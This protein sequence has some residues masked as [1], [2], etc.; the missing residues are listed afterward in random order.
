MFPSIFSDELG[1][2]I[3]KGLPII[4]SWGLEYVDL[5]GRVF[6][7]SAE[8][9]PADKLADLKKLFD[10]HGM[11]LGCIQSSLAKVH[12]PGA[13]RQKAEAEKLEG[14]IR[15]ADAL[16]CRLVRSFHYWQ[17]PKED[18]GQLA[19]RPD[20]LQKVLDMFAPLAE[21]AQKAGL[22]LAFE[23]CDVTPDEIFTVLDA[24]DVPQWGMAWDVANTWG[25]EEC[26]EDED[27]YILRMAKRARLLHV[28]ANGS[29]IPRD[30]RYIPYDK[31]LEVCHN[32]GMPGP[33]SVETHNPDRSV[34]NEEMSRRVVQVV[35]KAW[36][37]AAPGALGKPRIVRT[38]SRPWDNEPVGFVVVGLGM[39]QVRSKD[40]TRTSGT[41]LVGV[42]DLIEDRAKRVGEEFDVPWST[43]LAAWL[44]NDEVE[45]V[46]VITETG[47]HAK[48][49]CQALEAGKHVITTKPMEANVANCDKMIS[50][51]EEKGLL[52]GVDLG[53]RYRPETQ[54]LRAAVAAGK[55]G[56]LL[57]GN[58][59]LKILRDKKYFDHNG[60]W[61]GT[62]ALDG[63]G[64]MSNQAIHHID[65]VVY[66]VGMPE[67]VRC[68][69]WTMKHDIEAEDT[70]SAVW[71]YED[72]FVLTFTATTCYPQPTWY[73]LLELTGQDGA[74]IQT[75]GGPF[76]DPIIRYYIDGAWSDKAPA[77]ADF[78]WVNSADNF[79]AAVRTGAPLVATGRD[80]KRSRVV[81]DAMYES[82]YRNGGDWVDVVCQ[83]LTP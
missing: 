33:V 7:R 75:A 83:P 62:W 40:I 5:R 13:E 2:D 38:V 72:G 47:N 59:S 60:R 67:K 18:R 55:F 19:V 52:L 10:D 74:Y 42:C 46:F 71:L 68:N 23:N 53:R 45:V 50:L 37:T 26:L 54:E 79:A 81:L 1:L 27:A 35:R 61:R 65:E 20:E 17:P 80:G 9:L 82:A 76:E 29:V 49:A 70:A 16:D 15:L 44:S 25:C 12:L 4:K 73:Y 41:K 8:G 78:E 34:A 24:L 21:R 11:K 3:T 64:V 69:A 56:R 51:A 28:K 43:D 57:S 36:P 6:G 30:G 39:G 31:V 14:I 32:A 63:G 58:C 66:T 48:V 22:V 77:A